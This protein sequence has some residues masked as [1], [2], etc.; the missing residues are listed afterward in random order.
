MADGAVRVTRR[1]GA[2]L[3]AAPARVRAAA[4][5]MRAAAAR[6]GARIDA[7]P[8]LVVDAA[9]GGLALLAM[10]VERIATRST[11]DAPLPVALALTAVIAGCLVAR[12]V[13]PLTAYLVGTAALAAEALWVS[14]CPLTPYV[15]LVGVYSVGLYATRRRALV[16]AAAVLPGV[17]AYFAGEDVP[18]TVPAGVVFT[19]LLA[20]AAGYGAAR[21]RDRQTSA[22]RRMRREAVA[23]ERTRIA[24]ELHDLVG[25]TLTVMLVRAGAARLVLDSSPAQAREILLD[26]EVTGRRAL[27]ELDQVLGALRGD[28]DADLQPGLAELPHLARRMTEAGMA[29]AV[30]VDPPAEH[31]PRSLDLSAYRIVQEALTN[32]LRH[33]RAG[34][35]A[36]T[37]RCDDR[38]VRLEVR[39][40]GQGP[41]PG[42]RPGRGLLGIAERAALFAG[43]VEHGPVA[44]GGFRVRA[45]LP[46]PVVD[47]E[48]PAAHRGGAPP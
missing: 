20:W 39:D 9:L 14:S 48:E 2:E 5:Q 6:V 30:R 25:H 32:A 34:T 29:V 15:N 4:V 44:G 7:L 36:V 17:L 13:A 40:D 26:V 24:R 10:A 31:L 37:V 28:D 19:W 3:A 33:G 45:E 21:R 8:P 23:D 12:R 22:R 1:V 11:L 41:P 47:R 42:Y 46:L 16:G 35:A 43:A 38:R 27:D 18:P